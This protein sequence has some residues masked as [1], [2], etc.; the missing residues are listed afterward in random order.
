M[1]E[2]INKCV[3]LILYTFLQFPVLF[4]MGFGQW[5]VVWAF[6]AYSAIGC[7]TIML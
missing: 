1:I 7:I 3:K 2:Y 6:A 5:Y 4:C